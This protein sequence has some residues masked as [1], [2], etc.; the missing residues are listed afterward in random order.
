MP[1]VLPVGGRLALFYDAPGGD[2]MSHMGRNIGLAWF[3]LP[4][5]P[6]AE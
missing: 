5:K 2:S 4:L 3:D 6:P 1:S